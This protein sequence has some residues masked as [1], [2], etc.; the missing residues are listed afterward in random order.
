MG[1]PRSNL[2][3]NCRPPSKSSSLN[4]LR[5]NGL[6]RP[7][8]GIITNSS[9]GFARTCAA[10]L[11]GWEV[12]TLVS[13]SGRII[14]RPGQTHDGKGGQFVDLLPG[15]ERKSR[16]LRVA[17]ARRQHQLRTKPLRLAPFL[18]K[19]RAAILLRPA[20]EGKWRSRT[21]KR[22]SRTSERKSRTLA[23]KARTLVLKISFISSNLG[24]LST[25][26]KVLKTLF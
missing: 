2:A 13:F 6:S 5:D 11:S 20:H 12:S 3:W 7:A 1:A 8:V 4:S 15:R 14:H 9:L 21:N 19:S 25:D 23:W 26:L 18:G 10:N 17:Q 22:R 16:T 24:P